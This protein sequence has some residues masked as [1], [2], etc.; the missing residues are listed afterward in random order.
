MCIRDRRRVHGENMFKGMKSGQCVKNVA[1]FSSGASL[2]KKNS[3]SHVGGGS[4]F[5]TLHSSAS[6][7]NFQR[8]NSISAI[9]VA[10]QVITAPPSA[11]TAGLARS[12][13]FYDNLAKQKKSV[14]KKL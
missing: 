2:A 1:A 6:G 11:N 5:T 14:I 13:G 7:S 9:P 12:N 10:S 8:Q 3:M 4:G